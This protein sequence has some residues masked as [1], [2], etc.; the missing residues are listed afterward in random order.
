MEILGWCYNLKGF[1]NYR[2]F[3]DNKINFVDNGVVI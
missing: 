1:I 3:I 2:Y